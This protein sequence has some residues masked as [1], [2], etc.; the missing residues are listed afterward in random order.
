MNT[1]I[2]L[3]ITL[4]V[5]A[6]GGGSSGTGDIVN[7]ITTPPASTNETCSNTQVL[8]LKRCNLIH[9]NTERY[10]Y[11]YEPSNLDSNSSIPVLFALHGYGSSA[12]THFN[13]T[14]YEAIADENNFIV[15]YPQGTTSNGLNTHWNNGGWTSKSTAKDIEFIDT[16]INFLKDKI[17]IDQTRIYSSGM[18]NGGYMSY[19]LACNLDNKFAAVVSVTG[20]MTND[21]YDSCYPSHPTAAMQIHGIQDT[22][23]PYLG[24]GWSKSIEDVI[25]YWVNYNSCDS[26]PERLIK[27]SNQMG[28]INIDTYN[29]CINNVNVKLI[30]HPEMGH[31]WPTTQNYNIDASEEIWNFVSKYNL[32]GLIN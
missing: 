7:T 26:E 24:S 6:C 29:G 30:L 20:S 18:S 14:N 16:V 13:Y 8:N 5:S 3:L 21:T 17:S 25:N 9:N 27:Y 1:R 10:Y 32:Y 15:I 11:I 22:T 23:V 4:L 19:H 31:T 2:A 28:L 12:M